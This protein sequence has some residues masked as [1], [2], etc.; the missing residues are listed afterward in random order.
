MTPIN[1]SALRH[2]AF[3]APLL[4]TI[5]G[6]FLRD[7]GLVPHY[8]PLPAGANL[9][10]L[11]ERGEVQLA[12]SAVATGFAGLERGERSAIRHFAAINVRDGFFIA[13]RH[14]EP[15]FQWQQLVGR[16]LLADHFFQPLA[17]LRYGL[18]RQGVDWQQINVIDA[19][20]VVAID[21]AFRQGEG[22]YV[23]QQGPA[24]QQLAAEQIGYPVAAVGDAVGEVAFSS[25]CAHSSWL[26][27]DQAAAFTRGYQRARAWVQQAS[28]DA[29]AEQL[30]RFF[31]SITLPVLTTTVE[32][33]QQLGCWEGGIE[34]TE[35]SYERLLDVFQFSGGITQRHRYDTVVVAV[36][37]PLYP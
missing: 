10:A 19:G 6:D 18:H 35:R 32:R 11:L 30:H 36:P 15:H 4:V 16:S 24:P 14:P 37:N 13:G 31:P 1:I 17:M 8:Q 20:D 12:Q 33:Y 2:S 26:E 29:I 23:H 9:T 7:E 5:S 34:I 28:A 25:L 27:S 22:D 21:T 3:Y